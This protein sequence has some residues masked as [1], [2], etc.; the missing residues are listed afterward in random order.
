MEKDQLD[1]V[2]LSKL[3]LPF[4]SPKDY[5]ALLDDIGDASLVLI[6]EATHGSHEF[7]QVR[8]SITK[9]LIEEKGFQVIAV[10]GDWPEVHNI[11]TYIKAQSPSMDEYKALAAFDSFPSW[12]WY[13]YDILEF[14][15]WLRNYNDQL[16]DTHAKVSIY[17]LDLYSF[18][19]S[20]KIVI[21]YLEKHDPK[22]AE[23]ARVRYQCL[24]NY[25][26]EP[27]NY[28]YAVQD[29]MVPGCKGK[30]YEQL[31]ELLKIE[32]QQRE[33]PGTD[34]DE[35]LYITQSAKVV[36]GA[37]SYYGALLKGPEI[38]WNLRDK[39]MMET[40]GTLRQFYQ[41]TLGY[42]PK[43]IIWAHNSHVGDA[44]TTQ[45][46]H[47]KE[48]NIGQLA[49]QQYKDDCYLIGFSTYTGEVTA[50][51][52]WGG[53]TERKEVRPALPGSYE[54]IF[55]QL[56]LPNFLLFLNEAIS[57]RQP[58]LQRAIGVIYRPETERMSHYYY[59]YLLGQ[60]NAIIHI[61]KTT[62]VIPMYKAQ[63]WDKGELGTCASGL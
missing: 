36:V 62:A 29:G 26:K 53:H 14:V 19:S 15:R 61:D 10:E 9:H 51:S 39:H 16:I 21:A 55:H 43:M 49:K 13:N 8:A 4:N 45:T 17:G 25:A 56:E 22:A 20:M 47:R 24:R 44:R 6:G 42:V 5:S 40:V 1:I 11:N 35:Q 38:T 60:F 63:A 54:H 30:I 7:Y 32:L 52:T 41:N 34:L 2:N 31:I 59:S 3:I 12:V 37:E 57:L 58:R 48:I 18:H 33:E 46:A 50:A 27:V 28:A 23:L